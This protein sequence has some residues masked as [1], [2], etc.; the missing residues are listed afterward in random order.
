V[1]RPGQQPAQGFRLLKVLAGKKGIAVAE[2]QFSNFKFTKQ[3][4][5]LS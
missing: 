5:S 1:F 2:K 3:L 4:R